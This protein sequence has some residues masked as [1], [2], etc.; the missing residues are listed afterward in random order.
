MF[1]SN[2]RYI[3]LQCY[4]RPLVLTWAKKHYYPSLVFSGLPTPGK[5]GPGN[6]D[7]PV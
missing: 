3:F 6:I 1:D 5:P 2:K 7:H 4:F